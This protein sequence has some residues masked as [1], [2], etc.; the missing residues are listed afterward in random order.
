LAPPNSWHDPQ[1]STAVK[2]SDAQFT[3]LD[4]I[5]KDYASEID[6]CAWR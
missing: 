1:I 6:R 2:L 4:A 5:R 3:P